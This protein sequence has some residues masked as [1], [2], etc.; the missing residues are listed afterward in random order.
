MRVGKTWGNM[1]VTSS[2]SRVRFSC[3][4][5]SSLKYYGGYGDN[6]DGQDHK[7]PVTSAVHEVHGVHLCRR[8]GWPFPNPHP[9]AKHRRAHK[10][11]C[12]KIEGY[13]MSPSD[14]AISDDEHASDEDKQH[15]PSPKIEKSNVKESNG[16]GEVRLRSIKS[17]DDV[18]S[19]ARTEFSESAASPS[20]EERLE[21][22]KGDDKKREQK[23]VE[24][25]INVNLLRKVDD[26][27]DTTK[28]LNDPSSSDQI[29]TGGEAVSVEPGNHLQSDDIKLAS[30]SSN[31]KEEKA[32][33]P[34]I[35]A[36]ERKEE[37]HDKR[38][39]STHILDT[40][41][42]TAV[43]DKPELEDV[44]VPLAGKSCT[45]VPR[46]TSG[47]DVQFP[48]EN[49]AVTT[50]SFPVFHNSS[51]PED[52]STTRDLERPFRDEK[53]ICEILVTGNESGKG[54]PVEEQEIQP[55]YNSTN[56]LPSGEV[57]V[58]PRQLE[59]LSET[60]SGL[61]EFK[62]VEFMRSRQGSE[63]GN[64]TGLVIGLNL[65]VPDVV[66]VKSAGVED[67]ANESNRDVGDVFSE[68]TE[69]QPISKDSANPFSESF[70]SDENYNTNNSLTNDVRKPLESKDVVHED[71]E[72]KH[73]NGAVVLLEKSD[74][75]PVKV[76][77]TSP[78]KERYLLETDPDKCH[79]T[80]AFSI[81]V[82]AGIVEDTSIAYKKVSDGETDTVVDSSKPL[83]GES[84][85][86][87]K[88]INE[89]DSAS[90]ADSLEGKWGSISAVETNSQ[91]SPRSEANM[92]NSEHKNIQGH[93]SKSDDF[94]PPSFMTLVQ[95]GKVPDSVAAPTASEIE[96]VQYNQQQKTESLQAGWFP[97]LTN[98]V[99]ES[100]GRK[101][102]EE[103]I[104]KVT[105]WNAGKEH[106]GQLKILLNDA[107]SPKTKLQ[108][109]ET[110]QKDNSA[111]G[112]TVS[113]VVEPEE[114]KIEIPYKED[115]NS[116]A[117][118]P[119]VIKKEKKKGKPYWV[120]F[121]CCS[122]VNRDL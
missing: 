52:N 121:V 70:V 32:S 19:D 83:E 56:P 114:P 86:T 66:G 26:C 105:N 13:K 31:S 24:G 7:K 112:T 63:A 120:P 97:S 49:G 16:D 91:S 73:D 36:V 50:D 39:G 75:L 47:D 109:D 106:R 85:T 5:Y 8:C 43:E 81:P 78:V 38:D 59:S 37:P 95:P 40:T 108:K 28:K 3:G 77:E 29:Y 54:A 4:A 99:N 18:F 79:A 102:N 84:Y 2:T 104:A 74:S 35:L 101:K 92:R 96:P 51:A 42:F 44:E 113:P 21:V 41:K 9:S 25:D 68:K 17:E 117:R 10:S 118:Y 93:Q 116:P 69:E 1:G 72:Q 58:D 71:T 34:A 103:I 23:S 53:A 48:K 20:L 65:D 60:D 110:S 33:D 100:E 14:L 76:Q 80:E 11:V 62:D 55:S 30:M 22:S 119:T 107:K 82:S 115:W 88:L 98:V 12:G 45:L 6:M 89:K 15:T 61:L 27:A 122:S 90:A 46:E 67:V 64:T 87:D 111:A 94:E 57:E